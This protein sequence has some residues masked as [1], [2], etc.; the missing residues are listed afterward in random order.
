MIVKEIRLPF[1]EQNPRIALDD[2]F[3]GGLERLGR[4]DDSDRFFGTRDARIDNLVVQE[5][6]AGPCGQEHQDMVVFGTLGLVDGCRK[7]GFEHVCSELIFRIEDKAVIA[8]E[9]DAPFAFAAR[10]KNSRVA[11]IKPKTALV[12]VEHHDFAGGEPA[13]S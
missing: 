9:H 5:G 6:V 11:V 1:L 2:R 10:A 12:A 4:R 7:S 8:L 3:A 13:C